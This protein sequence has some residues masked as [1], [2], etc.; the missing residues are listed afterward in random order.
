MVRAPWFC[1]V[2]CRVS[3]GS[4]WGD[5][6]ELLFLG[7]L[8]MIGAVILLAY[9]IRIRLTVRE[10]KKSYGIPDGMI[11]YSDLNV[12]AAPLFSK[13]SRLAGK[14]DYIVRKE[15]HCIPVEVKSGGGAHP[16]QSHVLQLAA[17]CQ[18]LEDTS[19]MFVPEG[20]LVYNNVPYTIPFDPKLRF[21]L[22]SVMKSMRASLRN[23]VVKRNHQEPGRCRHCS[24]KRYCTDVVREGP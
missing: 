2:V 14:P 10:E 21:E 7:I 9:A 20:I 13:R 3:S 6:I 11:L 18:L 17:Y 4:P 16:H 1:G 15:N 8:L 24:M 19:G 5:F 12:L 22:E 23:G